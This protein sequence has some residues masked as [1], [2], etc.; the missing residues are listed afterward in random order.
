MVDRE[1]PSS[2][3]FPSS[4]SSSSASSAWASTVWD[5]DIDTDTDTDS[6]YAPSSSSSTSSFDTSP[7]LSAC[8]VRTAQSELV[9]LVKDES[10]LARLRRRRYPMQVR[11]LLGVGIAVAFV[12]IGAAAM[13]WALT[14]C[15]RRPPQQ[16]M[17]MEAVSAADFAD[18]NPTVRPSD[19]L[20]MRKI[21]FHL[22][23]KWMEW[24]A[25]PP[26]GMT[27]WREQGGE[28]QDQF[29]V[30]QN[31]NHRLG[32]RVATREAKRRSWGGEFG[33]IG[34]W[35][36][37]CDRRATK[38]MDS[39]W[40]QQ[41]LA[42]VAAVLST[43]ARSSRKTVD[44]TVM[45]PLIEDILSHLSREIT[46]IDLY[47]D[48]FASLALRCDARMRMVNAE[49]YAIAVKATTRQPPP[50]TGRSLVALLSS[51]EKTRIAFAREEYGVLAFSALLSNALP[52]AIRKRREEIQSLTTRIEGLKQ[53]LAVDHL[54][55]A[56]QQSR[57]LAVARN[58]PTIA[59]L[60][61]VMKEKLIHPRTIRTSALEW[62]RAH[63]HPESPIGSSSSSS[64]SSTTTTTTTT[65]LSSPPPAR[66]SSCLCNTPLLSCLCNTPTPLL[67]AH[68]LLYTHIWLHPVLGPASWHW[69]GS[70]PARTSLT[71]RLRLETALLFDGLD[72]EE[73]EEWHVNRLL[74]GKGERWEDRRFRMVDRED[75]ADL[76]RS[77]P[78]GYAGR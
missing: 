39:G 58:L 43:G 5:S 8:W 76:R 6:S 29:R 57:V 68:L 46:S 40:L 45:T 44:A 52:P 78:E 56:D 3:D 35:L 36:E 42:R 38:E 62:M 59:E 33:E 18:I 10:S 21:A 1:S 22:S 75:G 74:L 7:V 64:S 67:P 51:A 11:K 24:V 49:L 72:A 23:S 55:P 37:E 9:F 54:N 60:D 12:I 70:G 19:A 63:K 20:A 17:H 31:F 41:R 2:D 27:N 14:M 4:S 30:L 28:P 66:L 13:V 77:W 32:V 61:A 16:V 71:A 65:T 25:Q 48:V 69:E 26:L 50:P 15:C 47:L 73:Q 53:Q 34:T